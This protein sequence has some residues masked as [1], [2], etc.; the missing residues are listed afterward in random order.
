MAVLP[1]KHCPKQAGL[2]LIEVLIAL[3]IVGIAMTAI[4]KATSQHIR[5]TTY[6]QNKMV[7]AWVG[8]QVLNEVRAGVLTLPDDGEKLKQKTTMFDR[9]WYWQAER[10]DTPNLHINKISVEVFANNN[11]EDVSPMVSLESYVYH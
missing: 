4:I 6:L 2:T 3:A 1:V 9:E 10:H 8:E 7:A 11:D 5:A